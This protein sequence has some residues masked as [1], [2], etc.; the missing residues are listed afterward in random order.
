MK[1]LNASELDQ[2]DHAAMPGSRYLAVF[3]SSNHQP[4]EEHELFYQHDWILQDLLDLSLTVHLFMMDTPGFV[5]SF[6][7]SAPFYEINLA[8]QILLLAL[9]SLY[10]T[11]VIETINGACLS[12]IYIN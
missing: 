12:N 4:A 1:T 7:N 5:R 9:K 3:V 10:T 11:F 6:F 2:I 8:R